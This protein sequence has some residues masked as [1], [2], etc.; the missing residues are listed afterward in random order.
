M[1]IHFRLSAN[2]FNFKTAF[3]YGDFEKE[4]YMECPWGTSDLDRDEYIVLEK[5]IYFFVQAAR[6]YYKKTV[7]ILKKL[8]FIEGNVNPSFMLKRV[9][10]MIRDTEAID[11][12]ITAL[13]EN[14]LVLKVVEGL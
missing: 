1:V 11:K 7:E 6:W 3:L 12:A 14:G 4:I 5:F 2:I 10:R 8:G 9:K 13:K